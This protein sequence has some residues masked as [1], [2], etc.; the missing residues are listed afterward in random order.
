MNYYFDLHTHTIASGHA[1]S[2][3]QEMISAAQKKGLELIGISDH[4]PCMP[5]S[6]YIYYF[7]NLRVVPKEIDGLKVMVGVEANIIDHNG[8]IDMNPSDLMHLD[9]VIASFHPPC[10]KPSSK[11]HNTKALIKTIENPFVN[12]IGH[13]DDVRYDVDYKA[14]VLAAKENNVL[15]EVNNTSL[16]PKGFRKDSAIATKQVLEWC[17]HYEHP[18]ILGSDAHISYDVG[19]FSYCQNL[20]EAISFPEHLVANTSIKMLTEYLDAKRK[21]RP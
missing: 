21:I 6:A 19:N 1:Y 15:L 8:K 12:I 16:S 20:I 10:I 17:M 5:G 14:I 13:P 11:K 4:A 7:Q 2:T 3:I 9:Y 18:V